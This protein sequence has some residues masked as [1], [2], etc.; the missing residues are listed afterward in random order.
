MSRRRTEES[1]IR[2]YIHL[3]KF[4]RRFTDR[5]VKH[6][7]NFKNDKKRGEKGRQELRKRLRNLFK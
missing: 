5:G 2:R 4:I 7:H 3:P 6:V 1:I